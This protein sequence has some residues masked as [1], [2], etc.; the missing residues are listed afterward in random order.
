MAGKISGPPLDDHWPTAPKTTHNKIILKVLEYTQIQLNLQDTNKPNHVAQIAYRKTRNLTGHH[1]AVRQ[2]HE[3]LI[4]YVAPKIKFL[5]IIFY[6]LVTQCSLCCI[7]RTCTFVKFGFVKQINT[8][9]QT[10]YSHGP[11][12]PGRDTWCFFSLLKRSSAPPLDNK[13]VGL[14]KII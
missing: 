3:P 10:W 8:S 12:W 6:V 1:L 5:I 9:W 13:R 11:A 4:Y 7:C 2:Q 14:I